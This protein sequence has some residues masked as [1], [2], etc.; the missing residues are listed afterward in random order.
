MK[1]NKELKIYSEY[2][3]NTWLNDVLNENR[4]LNKWK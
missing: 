4:N 3:F 1:M 2:V